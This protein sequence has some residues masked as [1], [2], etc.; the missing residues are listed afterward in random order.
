MLNII[1]KSSFL[2]RLYYLDRNIRKYF[3]YNLIENSDFIINDKIKIKFQPINFTF[4]FFLTFKTNNYEKSNRITSPCIFNFHILY[5]E[6]LPLYKKN[7]KHFFLSDI[8]IHFENFCNFLYSL[9]FYEED[10]CD[11]SVQTLCVYVP[12]N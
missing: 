3:K 10:F 5:D 11:I 4:T 2:K 6:I 12:L 1:K 7:K 9:R 8:N